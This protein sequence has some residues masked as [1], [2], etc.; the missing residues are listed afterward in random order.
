MHFWIVTF[1]RAQRNFWFKDPDRTVWGNRGPDGQSV[2][3][4]LIEKRCHFWKFWWYSFTF[5]INDCTIVF[6]QFPENR[7]SG[8]VL[9][10]KIESWF[11]KF[12]F[13]NIPRFRLDQLHFFSNI[14]NTRGINK[15]WSG[16]D[17][18]RSSDKTSTFDSSN[19]TTTSK[20]DGST[21]SIWNYN[22]VKSWKQLGKRWPNWTVWNTKDDSSH[23]FCPQSLHFFN[24][25]I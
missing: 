1:I 18:N 6:L 14:F 5:T 2:I 8:R 10:N 9:F 24:F 16:T 25:K 20:V 15:I 12:C 4:F 19:L 7:W 11:D 3:P 13:G 17:K 23:L 22:W 21:N